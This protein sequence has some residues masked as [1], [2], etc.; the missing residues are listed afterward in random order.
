MYNVQQ[1]A[2]GGGGVYRE[3]RSVVYHV[4]QLT[5]GGGGYREWRPV[6]YHVQQHTGGIENGGLLC[7]MYN[8][9]QG[10]GGGV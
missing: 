7:T 5:R 1:L 3:W 8:N 6:V 9:L 4:Q 10:G 2:G